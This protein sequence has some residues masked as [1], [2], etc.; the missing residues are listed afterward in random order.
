MNAAGARPHPHPPRRAL[1]ARFPTNL[2][3]VAF[4][5]G[6]FRVACALRALRH[7]APGV[8][9]VVVHDWTERPAYGDALKPFYDVVEVADRL[10]VLT[11][12][13][14]VDWSEWAAALG[15]AEREPA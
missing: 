15:R 1:R 2:V 8:G 10:A 6:R 3:D 14:A 7:V 5:D 13:L 9:V 4:V 12:K 11:P